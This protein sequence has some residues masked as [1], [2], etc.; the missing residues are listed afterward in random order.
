MSEACE[1]VSGVIKGYNYTH[2]SL[3]IH[4]AHFELPV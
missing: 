2:P 4:F 3:K 1:Q